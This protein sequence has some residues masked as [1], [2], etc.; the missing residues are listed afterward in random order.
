MPTTLNHDKLYIT[1]VDIPILLLGDSHR[2]CLFVALLYTCREYIIQLYPI[3]QDQN[4]VFEHVVVSL[5]YQ[6]QVHMVRYVN[7]L[8]CY[9]ARKFFERN[10]SYI[11]GFSDREQYCME[12]KEQ[13]HILIEVT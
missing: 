1:L 4:K 10:S 9:K 13:T 2:K 8:G 7:V 5:H 12:G 6:P 11:R 3:A